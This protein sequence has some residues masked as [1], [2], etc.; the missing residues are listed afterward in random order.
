MDIRESWEWFEKHGEPVQVFV[1]PQQNRADRFGK[2]ACYTLRDEAAALRREVN[3]YARYVGTF[4]R[5]ISIQDYR[6][7]VLAVCAANRSAE[8]E[9]EG[10][11][12]S[13][14]RGGQDGVPDDQPTSPGMGLR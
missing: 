6:G 13:L 3:D 7:E 9:V 5:G 8:S 12:Q 14:G 10:I 2:V 11:L 1:A 4:Q